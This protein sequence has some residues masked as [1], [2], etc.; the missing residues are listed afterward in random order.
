VRRRLSW[1]FVGSVIGVAVVAAACVALVHLLRDVDVGKVGTALSAT[2]LSA[3]LLAVVLIA[4]SYVTLTFYDFFA[5]RTIGQ[6]HIPYR[7]AALTGLLS[8]TIGHN[9]GATVVTAGAVRFRIYKAWGLSLIDVAKIAFITGLTFWLGNAVVLGTGIAYAPDVAA[10]LNRLPDWLNRG[11]ALAALAVIAGY[12]VWLLPRPRAI[13][14]SGWQLKLPSARLTLVQIGIGI[15]DLCLAGLAMYLLIAVHAPVQAVTAVIA[16]VLAALLGFASHSPGGL[17]VFDAAM[18]IAL[19][20][21]E[22]E[23]LLAALLIFRCLY[24]LLPFL[25]AVLILATWELWV[26][27]NNKRQNP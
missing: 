5:L 17:G 26:S 27:I 24:F 22:K 19:P 13:G 18:L 6:T 7:V 2:P 20:Q 11:I 1:D 21:V 14:R 15:A 3:V 9:L 12:L 4:G 25:V 8:Y 10:A 16:Y 23:Q